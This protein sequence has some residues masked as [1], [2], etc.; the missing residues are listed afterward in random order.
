MATHTPN[1]SETKIPMQ[2]ADAEIAADPTF[3]VDEK[4]LLRKLDS[5]IIPLVMLL[6]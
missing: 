1:M 2:D 5:H 3:G 6:C 4:K